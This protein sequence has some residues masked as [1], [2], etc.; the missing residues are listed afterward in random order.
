MVYSLGITI[1]DRHRRSIWQSGTAMERTS[2]QTERDVCKTHVFVSLYLTNS[3][4]QM[5]LVPEK[6]V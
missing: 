2:S 5:K 4:G 3:H 1:R 6:V